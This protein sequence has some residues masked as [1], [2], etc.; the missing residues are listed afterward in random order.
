MLLGPR[1]ANARIQVVELRG[2]QSYGL[3]LLLVSLADLLLV[4]AVL[5]ALHLGLGGLDLLLTELRFVSEGAVK[6]K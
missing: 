6:Q 2:A 1:N 5:R 3:I 4:Q